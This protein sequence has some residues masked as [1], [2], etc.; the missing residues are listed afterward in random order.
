[1]TIKTYRILKPSLIKKYFTSLLDLFYPKLCIACQDVLAGNEEYLCSYCIANLPLTNFWKQKDN[2]VEQLFWGRVKVEQ[3]TSLF[4]FE[5]ESRYQNIL[6]QLKYKGKK[7]IGI[8]LGR[9]LGYYLSES[10]FKEIDAIVPVPLHPKRQRKRGYNQ[11]EMIALG[12]STAMQK[13]LL[14]DCVSRLVHTKSQTKKNRYSRWENVS[15]IFSV[16]KPNELQ[17]KHILVVD[18]VITTGSTIEALLE[19][20]LKTDNI[21]VSVASL[22][23]A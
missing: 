7:N 14:S 18:D 21:K 15:G 12:I 23:V 20:I 10:P 6:H 9:I 13:P 22:A 11:S 5:K 4:Y 16:L 17:G 3:A 1:M 2:L 19:E 8:Q